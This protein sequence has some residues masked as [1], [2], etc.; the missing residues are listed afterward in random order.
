MLCSNEFSIF[1]CE[2]QDCDQLPFYHVGQPGDTVDILNTLFQGTEELKPC[3]TFLL[4]K[5]NTQNLSSIPSVLVYFKQVSR[6][7]FYILQ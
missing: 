7:T 1:F 6:K 2:Q 4:S 5:L 3:I